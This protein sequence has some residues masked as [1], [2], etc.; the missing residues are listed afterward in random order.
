LRGRR[1]TALA[2]IGAPQQFFDLLEAAGLSILPLPCS[3]HA[4]YT[5]APWPAGK[6]E[7][8]TTEKDA[9][10]LAAL[11]A[12][13]TPVWVLPL[14]CRLPAALLGELLAALGPIRKRHR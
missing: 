5:R 12:L 9:V 2:G 11:P 10:K 1:L 6:R 13:Q 3:D 8:I 14:D 7:V 4:E